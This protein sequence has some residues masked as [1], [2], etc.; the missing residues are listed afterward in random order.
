[1]PPFVRRALQ[2]EGLMA[3]YRARPPYQQN[4]YLDW[5]VRAKRDETQ[6]KRLKEMIQE[7]SV[8]GLYM[9]MNHAPSRKQ[10]KK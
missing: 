4:D 9:N 7:L 6:L 1:M 10:G 5:I 3:A 8:G 2:D